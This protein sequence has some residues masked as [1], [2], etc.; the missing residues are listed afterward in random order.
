MSCV[1]MGLSTLAG[2][3]I[4]YCVNFVYCSIYSFL[5]VLSMALDSFSVYMQ[6]NTQQRSLRDPM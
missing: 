1:L 3:N 4:N 2:G 5:V 6:M